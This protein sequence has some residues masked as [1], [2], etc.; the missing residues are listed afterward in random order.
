MPPPWFVAQTPLRL[1]RNPLLSWRCDKRGM[2]TRATALLIFLLSLWSLAILSP[3]QPGNPQ[4]VTRM[5]LVLSILDLGQ[6][7][8]TPFADRTIDKARV[9]DRYYADKTPGHPLLALPAVALVQLV[10]RL[11]GAPVDPLD[12][13]A[14]ADEVGWATFGT[15]VWISALAVAVAFVAALD[16]GASRAGAL[17]A[18][19]CL[20]WATPFFGW[21]TAFFAHSVTGSFLLFS[22]ALI[23]RQFP[24]DPTSREVRAIPILALGLLLG[25]TLVVDLTAAPA[26]AILGLFAFAR[27]TRAGAAVRVTLLLAAGGIV[28]LLPLLV[29]NDLAFGSPLHLGYAN[30]DFTGMEQGFFGVTWPNPKVLQQILF[31][32]YRGLLPLSPVLILVPFGLA[33]VA[34]RP[35]RRGPVI[36]IALIVAAY[37]W[38]NASYFYWDGGFSTGPRHLIAML[39]VAALGL[40]FVRP[41]GR[42]GTAIIGLLLAGSLVLSLA[43][44]LAGMFAPSTILNPIVDWIFPNAFGPGKLGK[45]LLV[46]PAWVVM[47]VLVHRAR[48]AAPRPVPAPSPVAPAQ[49]VSG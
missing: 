15:N 24:P 12:R 37:L 31:G 35:E 6:L 25:Y 16:L 2:S 40:A 4:V 23:L 1:P 36:V 27:A 18:A 26:V 20:G 45:A 30:T 44:G 21:S 10:H 48:R 49:T 28:G 43:S 5:A 13:E 8:I 11:A 38:I 39:P 3:Q 9:G 29:Y 22:L 17:L 32:F 34:A 41:S 47:L 42:A 19:F 7:E 14:F 33:A 46:V